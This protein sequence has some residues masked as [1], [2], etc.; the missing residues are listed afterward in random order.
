MRPRPLAGT[1]NDAEVIAALRAGDERAFLTLVKDVHPAMVR[2]ASTF[3]SS[4]DIAEEVVQEAWVG[5]LKGLPR[6]EQRSSLRSWIMVIVANCARSRG[7][8]EAR[9]IPFSTVEDADEEA[10][11]PSRFLPESDP[12]YPG[13]WAIPPAPWPDEQVATQQTLE[14]VRRAIDV[15]PPNQRAVIT[16]RDV[17]GWSSEE[18]CEA[19]GISDVHQRVLLHRARSRV[20]AHLEEYFEEEVRR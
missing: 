2:V 1:S 18:T 4:P 10:V 6:F 16:M 15:L 3:V 20:R 11:D 14:R 13:H 8:R 19:L 5:V 17:H 7:V 12:H 9:S